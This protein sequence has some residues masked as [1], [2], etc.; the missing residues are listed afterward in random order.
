MVQQ[1]LPGAGG[2]AFVY[3]SE[4]HSHLE[5]FIVVNRI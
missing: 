1:G 2:L 4:S 3:L 5:G